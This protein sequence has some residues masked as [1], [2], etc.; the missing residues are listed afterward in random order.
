MEVADTV[1]DMT[2][3]IAVDIVLDMV[4]DMIVDKVVDIVVVAALA[5]CKFAMD[6]TSSCSL[7]CKMNFLF[8]AKFRTVNEKC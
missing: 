2:A 1:V 6:Y 4:V 7:F 8:Q 3:G 5:K